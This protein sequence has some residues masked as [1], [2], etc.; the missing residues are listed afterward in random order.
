MHEGKET[1]ALFSVNT[2]DVS[3]DVVLSALPARHVGFWQKFKE[4]EP[5]NQ[6]ALRAYITRHTIVLD[7]GAWVGPISLLSAAL[8]AQRVI[9]LEPDPDAFHMLEK[10]IRANPGFKKVIQTL[11]I[12]ISP[13][14]NPVQLHSLEG[15]DFGESTTFVSDNPGIS[16]EST[17]LNT[18]LKKTL[19]ETPGVEKIVLKID[20]EGGEKDH[21]EEVIHIAEETEHP[22]MILMEV[23]P[24]H[25]SFDNCKDVEQF[26]RSLEKIA[27]RFSIHSNRREAGELPVADEAHN[28]GSRIDD[29]LGEIYHPNGLFHVIVEIRPKTHR[30]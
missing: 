6:E 9:A 7:I 5:W 16:T 24:F 13:G 27:E 12:A 23:H 1:P 2:G 26:L 25:F 18:I 15:R 30:A 4:W 11:R 8:G 22:L 19:Y 28:S 10:N 29:A 20:I 14:A 21:L 17:A 3:F